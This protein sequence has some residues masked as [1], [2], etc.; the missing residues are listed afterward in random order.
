[1]SR[2]FMLLGCASV[3]LAQEW[4]W[5]LVSPEWRNPTGFPDDVIAAG[6]FDGDGLTELLAPSGEGWGIWTRDTTTDEMHWIMSPSVFPEGVSFEGVTV[7]N[8]DEDDAWEIVLI[9]SG[10]ETMR[11]VK[12][13]SARPWEWEW[14]DELLEE[15]IPEEFG[16]APR[17]FVVSDFDGDELRECILPVSNGEGTNALRYERNASGIW[18]VMDTLDVGAVG[19]MYGAPFQVGDFDSDGDLD[20]AGTVGEFDAGPNT[21]AVENF[22]G[23]FIVHQCD[24][25]C[26]M[27]WGGQFDNDLNWEFIG[28]Q[29]CSLGGYDPELFEFVSFGNFA[30][31][32]AVARLNG[33]MFGNLRTSNGCRPMGTNL[34]FCWNGF[35]GPDQHSGIAYSIANDWNGWM[36]F[37]GALRRVSLGDINEDGFADMLVDRSWLDWNWNLYYAMSLQLNQ[38]D[39]TRDVFLPI[40]GVDMIT[41]EY[42]FVNMTPPPQLGDVNGDGMAEILAM[43]VDSVPVPVR[44]LTVFRIEQLVPEEIFTIADDLMSGLPDTVSSFICP[45][46]DGDGAVE[47][48]ATVD[49]DQHLYF[50]RNGLWVEYEGILPEEMGAVQG[51]ADWN[52]DGTNDLFTNEGVWLNLTPSHA[53][54][55]Q[56]VVPRGFEMNVYPNPFNPSATLQFQLERESLV[57]A[58]VFDLTGRE[59]AMLA[60]ESYAAG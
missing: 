32:R 56:A 7:Q 31:E 53:R 19:A 2:I 51:F 37:G 23:E 3:V 20:F 48:L 13:V 42:N 8:M 33:G 52:G 6:D 55:E 35:W 15:Q 22:D 39:L 27:S 18:T 34:Q 40:S 46:L 10:F 43:N 9:E 21:I 60:N 47:L 24:D 30:Y 5:E 45:D 38:A 26:W 12:A 54:D 36:S 49:G 59:V 57:K 29:A 44:R 28:K 17:P 50:F 41:P 11:L 25:M 14:H 58:R 1:M 16:L 4:Q